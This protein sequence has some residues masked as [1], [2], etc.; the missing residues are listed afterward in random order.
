M[1]HN[2]NKSLDELLELKVHR[3]EQTLNEFNV[4][5]KHGDVDTIIAKV[6]HFELDDALTN[7]IGS[8]EVVTAINE[9]HAN[10]DDI[11]ISNVVVEVTIY[12]A[13]ATAK[14]LSPIKHLVAENV[15]I[16]CIVEACCRNIVF[17]LSNVT[18]DNDI[19]AT[20]NYLFS[21]KFLQHFEQTTSQFTLMQH[22]ANNM[23]LSDDETVYAN[24]V[25]NLLAKQLGTDAFVDAIEDCMT[26]NEV[27]INVAA[28]STIN[29]WIGKS[30]RLATQYPQIRT[31]VFDIVRNT[32]AS[33]IC[34]TSMFDN[35]RLNNQVRDSLASFNDMVA[36][37]DAT[38]LAENN[39]E[40]KTDTRH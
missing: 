16:D 39:A 6:K 26:V 10:N 20:V 28:T 40:Y 27:D 4:I 21:T 24:A 7:I 17:V 9:W 2:Q 12:L 8:H 23:M 18:K 31:I 22:W 32:F 36:K 19:E 35:D 3:I 25:S 13:T 29:K 38:L 15:S 34:T 1:E 33:W 5:K 30:I 11:D 37:F 14:S